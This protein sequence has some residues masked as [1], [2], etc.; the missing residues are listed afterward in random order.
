MILYNQLMN[1]GLHYSK[2][3]SI[4]MIGEAVFRAVLI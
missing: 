3:G 2:E 4:W 1:F